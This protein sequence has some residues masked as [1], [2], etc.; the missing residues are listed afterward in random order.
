MCSH[1]CGGRAETEWEKNPRCKKW[2]Q[3]PIFRVHFKTV[4]PNPT[5]AITTD[6]RHGRSAQGTLPSNCLCVNMSAV[7]Y[8]NLPISAPQPLRTCVNIP[9]TADIWLPLGLCKEV[10]CSVEIRLI[11]SGDA[12]ISLGMRP[13]NERRRYN[14]TTL[15]DWVHT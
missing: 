6:H 5:S 11:P 14:V 1:I 3:H 9:L 2:V 4:H 8:Q 7:E 10:Q 15:I 12:G 13:A